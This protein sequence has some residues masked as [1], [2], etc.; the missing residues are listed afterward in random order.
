M[1]PKWKERE[2]NSVATSESSKPKTLTAERLRKLSNGENL[3][4]ATENRSKKWISWKDVQKL[5]NQE[6]TRITKNTASKLDD[7]E[8]LKKLYYDPKEPG[9]FGGVKRLTEASGLKKS[10]VK[11]FLSGEDCHSL[12]F[13][14]RYKFHRRKTI[15][16]GVNELWQSDLV[17]L[18]KLSRFNKGYRYILT[19]IEV[20][21]NVRR[22]FRT[23]LAR[24]IT[25]NSE[26]ECCLSEATIP[27]KYFTVQPG[28]NDFYSIQHEIDVKTETLLPKFNIPLYNDDHADFVAGFNDMEKNFIDYP[29][30]FTLIKNN[31][32][33]KIELKRGWD[34]II[35]PAK[36]NQPLKFL[37]VDPNK[38]FI[39]THKPQGFSVTRNYLTPKK[40]IFKNQETKL[41][42]R[43]SILD[44]T[45]EIKLEGDLL[46]QINSKLLDVGLN[47]VKFSESNGQ[48]IVTL[49]FNVNIEFKRDSCPKLMTALNII[50]D[51]YV[52]RGEQLKIQFLYTRPAIDS[53]FPRVRLHIPQNILVT[54]GERLKDLLGFVQRTFTHVDYKSEYPLELRAGITEVYVYCDIVSESLVGDSSASIPKIIPVGNDH[55]DQNVK[56]FTV[57]LY[58]RVKKQFFD[59]I[60]IE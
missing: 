18:Q 23:K 10:R 15:A 49:P 44:H 2:S 9:S 55:S 19:F 45:Y 20:M 39:I 8:R 26:W 14:V 31:R 50:D 17:D 42:A 6:F 47:D 41:I 57:H 1:D 52:I 56:Y 33:I 59:L 13:P 51:A 22:H 21:Q 40:E 16:Y 36:G 28:Y 34:W 48:I 46:Q 38:D 3:L 43:E 54:F 12:H 32:Q 24:P 37:R 4:E 29:L 58:F 60:E 27:G 53:R 11:S 35:T 30:V 7:V 5:S 25:L